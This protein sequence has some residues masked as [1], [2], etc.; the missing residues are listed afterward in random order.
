MLMCAVGSWLVCG[1]AAM[2]SQVPTEDDTLRLLAESEEPEVAGH[3]F[4]CARKEVIQVACLSNDITNSNTQIRTALA[5]VII[6][7]TVLVLS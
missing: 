6:P 5:A 7:L 4:T 1:R 3:T 2:F